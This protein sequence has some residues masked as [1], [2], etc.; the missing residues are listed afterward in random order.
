MRGTIGALYN[1]LQK[2]N[3]SGWD[4]SQFGKGSLAALGGVGAVAAIPVA[5]SLVGVVP[6]AVVVGAG[7]F[8]ASEGAMAAGAVAV[9]VVEAGMIGGGLAVG[10]VAGGVAA[11]GGIGE[12]EW[13]DDSRIRDWVRQ[14]KHAL[15]VV[16]GLEDISS[17][18][19][20][21]LRCWFGASK[22]AAGGASTFLVSAPFAWGAFGLQRL[23]EDKSWKYCY[24]HPD[25]GEILSN[26]REE[27]YNI[28]NSRGVNYYNKSQYDLAYR[29]FHHAYMGC[30]TGY[31][32]KQLFR[33]NRDNAKVELDAQGL[34]SEGDKL[35]SGGKYSEA[36][37]K[38]Q[39]AANKS[40]VSNNQ[41]IYTANASKAKAELDAQGLNSEGD[42]LFSGGKYSEAQSK[43]QEAVNK[44]KVSNNQTI[45]AAN[46]SKAKAELIKLADEALNIYLF[47]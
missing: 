21:G 42:K 36:Q 16:Q 30:P 7:A 45:Y 2:D 13:I 1:L 47:I 3:D 41:T 31:K 4:W 17:D 26:S 37:S 6:G 5:A 38:Y 18:H 20:L 23:F 24:G 35:F 12:G 11:G 10:A 34:N 33:T 8:A 14:H 9:G 44:S 46:A 19:L 25:T 15:S 28:L 27:A 40:K 22:S 29:E 32:D 43:Y 39:E